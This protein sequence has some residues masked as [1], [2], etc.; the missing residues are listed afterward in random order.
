MNIYGISQK[1]LIKVV[2]YVLRVKMKNM[3]SPS[4]PDPGG[5][6]RGINLKVCRIM[7]RSGTLIIFVII[8]QGVQSPLVIVDL[9]I[10]DSLVIVDRLSRPVVYFSMY[11]SHN[12]GLSCYSEQFAADGQ[13]HYY[14]RRL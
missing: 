2:C 12:S 5:H 13:I 14:K 10:V 1:S 11:F 8:F 7:K 6:L 4:D 9:L 3:Q